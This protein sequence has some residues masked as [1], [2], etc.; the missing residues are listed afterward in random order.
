MTWN[1]ENIQL[2]LVCEI[3]SFFGYSSPS[4]LSIAAEPQIDGG[5]LGIIRRGPGG[6]E[7]QP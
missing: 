5:P 1:F 4:S 2:Q 6:G 3:V 7:R